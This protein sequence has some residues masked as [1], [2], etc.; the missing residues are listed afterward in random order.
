M[1]KVYTKFNAGVWSEEL[2]GR[3]DLGNTQSASK[4]CENFIPTRQGQVNKRAGTKFLGAAKY[5]DKKIRLESFTYSVNTKFILEFGDLY[6]RFWSN[7]LQVQDGGSPL[8]VATTY[9]EDEVADLQI[10]AINDV[11][12]IT[13]P[14]HPVARLTR[15]SDTDWEFEENGIELPFVDPDVVSLDNPLI[16]SGTKGDITLTSETDVFTPDMVGSELQLRWQEPGRTEAIDGSRDPLESNA[17]TVALSWY[18]YADL[19]Q[20]YPWRADPWTAS[21][22]ECTYAKNYISLQGGEKEYFEFYTCIKDTFHNPWASGVDYKVGDMVR[23]LYDNCR[24][25]KNHTS[26][27]FDDDKDAG[28]IIEDDNPR[29]FPEF[30]RAGIPMSRVVECW[31]KWTFTTAGTWTGSVA[32]QRSID[33]G[34][35]WNTIK[36]CASNA[37]NNYKIEGD[38]KGER[39]LLRIVKLSSSTTIDNTSTGEGVGIGTSLDWSLTTSPTPVYGVVKVTGYTDAKNISVSV[40]GAELPKSNK[41]LSWKESAFSLRQGYPRALAIFDGR[42]V[43]AGTKRMPQAF[44]YS[45]LNRYTEFNAK[46]TLAD[47]A[48]FIQARSEDQSP[49]QWLSAQRDL[50]VGTESVEGIVRSRKADEAQSAVNLPVIRWNESIGSAYKPALQIRD[51]TILLQRGQRSINMI[52]YVLERDGY[53]G[54]EVSLMC[55]HLLDGK[56]TQMAA[57][58]EPYTGLYA[59]VDGDL[60][61]LVFEPKLQVTSWCLFTFLN[62]SVKSVQTLANNDGDDEV[63]VAVQR[64]ISGSPAMYIERFVSGNELKQYDRDAESMWYLDSAVH[65]KGVAT[66]TITGLDH[67]EGEAVSVLADGVAG[68]YIVNTGSITLDFDASEVLVGLPIVSEFEP[69]DLEDQKTFGEKK[70]LLQTKIMVH[71]SLGGMISSDNQDYQPII[72]HRAGQAMDSRIPLRDGYAEIMHESRHARRQWWRIKHDTPYPFT[73]QAV[74]QS[75]TMRKK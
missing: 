31:G 30:F 1:K 74:V 48:F 50:F 35:S 23:H 43:L 56:V 22:S 59:V 57:M 32:V 28:L 26:T 7:D 14:D 18:H 62:G 73:L 47:E 46:T 9:T 2:R 15:N 39:N 49:I 75:Y 58:S 10:K 67:L 72:Y 53:A 51:N 64:D 38:E 41:T 63:Y 54:E 66:K 37:D 17:H 55:P 11:V 4:T 25:L 27:V 24:I 70:Q 5:G 6:I 69:F 16:P 21:G 3:V 42:L 52:A 61:H 40:Q 36:T 68:N 33:G 12:F 29:S 44:F 65:Y 34:A 8:E 20:N 71:R 45:A 60:T 19:T 13:H